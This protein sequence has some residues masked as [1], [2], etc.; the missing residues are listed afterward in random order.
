ME[1][2]TFIKDLTVVSTGAAITVPLIQP[3][4]ANSPNESVNIA[5]IGIRSWGKDHYRA[6]AQIPNVNIVAIC[7]IDQ[8]LSRKQWLKLKNLRARNPL[9]K[10]N[11]EKSLRTK[12]LMRFHWQLQITGMHYKLFGPVRPGKMY[13]WKNPF[14]TP[15]KKGGKW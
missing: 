7:D 12:R 8:R 2:R 13:M 10:L 6:L 4:W 1:R 5:V 15:S 14:R 3:A 9:P 11:T